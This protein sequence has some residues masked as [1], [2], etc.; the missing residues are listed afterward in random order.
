MTDIR[1]V[2]KN[3]QYSVFLG[4]NSE[5]QMPIYKVEETAAEWGIHPELV[6]QMK[7]IVE[8]SK[9]GGKHFHK[10]NWEE[11]TDGYKIVLE[12]IEPEQLISYMIDNIGTKLMYPDVVYDEIIRERLY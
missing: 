5:I 7:A 9:I 11:F 8:L 4:E 6:A 1:V 10:I 3:Q 2:R 12:I